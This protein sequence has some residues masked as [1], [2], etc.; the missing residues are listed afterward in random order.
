[1]NDP[2][3]D[4]PVGEAAEAN[5]TDPYR[6]QFDFEAGEDQQFLNPRYWISPLTTTA[7][8]SV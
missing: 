6:D 4:R 7:W 3:L 1:M 8:H 2:G 5:D